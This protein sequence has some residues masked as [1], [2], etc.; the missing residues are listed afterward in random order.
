MRRPSIGTRLMLGALAALVPATVLVATGGWYLMRQSLIS[1]ADS[2]L[3]ARIDGVEHYIEQMLRD[4]PPEGLRDELHEYVE[5]SEGDVLL[6]V[7]DESGDMLCGP[8]VSGWNTSRIEREL[9]ARPVGSMLFSNHAPRHAPY[10]LAGVRVSIGGE[11]FRIL[12][13]MPMGSSIEAV[14]R[15]GWVVAAA[16]PIVLVAGGLGS[17]WMTRRAL[18]PVDRITRTVRAITLRDLHRR[19]DVPPEDDELS[20]LTATFN[21]MLGR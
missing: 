1:A 15:Y 9:A 3:S 21:D 6:E 19:L 8:L 2:Q 20:R 18:A 10:R 16:L 14:R 5:L 11:E 4:E 12:S 17:Y 13:A 7:V